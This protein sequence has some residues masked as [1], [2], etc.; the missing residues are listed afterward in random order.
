MSYRIRL[1][2]PLIEFIAV[3]NLLPFPKFEILGG[4]G[5]I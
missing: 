4:G 5:G 2:R 1:S 3:W